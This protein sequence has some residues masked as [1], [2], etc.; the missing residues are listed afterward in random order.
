MSLCTWPWAPRDKDPCPL[1][2]AQRLVN[3]EWV[4]PVGILPF[5]RGSLATCCFTT[6]RFLLVLCKQ[7]LSTQTSLS[8]NAPSGDHTSFFVP[9]SVSR[10]QGKQEPCHMKTQMKK[11]ILCIIWRL[12]RNRWR[13]T[14]SKTFGYFIGLVALIN[15]QSLL[16]IVS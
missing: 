7:A 9:V 4:Q 8:M 15:Q 12:S 2:S 16:F 14:I 10:L 13:V 3:T 5:F 1:G 11:Q 6:D